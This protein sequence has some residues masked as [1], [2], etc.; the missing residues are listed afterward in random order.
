[1]GVYSQSFLGC[2]EF[3]DLGD[4]LFDGLLCGGAQLAPDVL[5]VS[6]SLRQLSENSLLDQR[7]GQESRVVLKFLHTHR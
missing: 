6:Y 7:T 3:A 5:P 2:F 4:C 1:M